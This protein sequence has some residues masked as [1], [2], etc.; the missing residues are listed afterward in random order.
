MRLF[1]N[2]FLAA[3]FS[4]TMLSAHACEQYRGLLTK[5]AIQTHG[6][7]APVAMLAGHIEQES[8]C[9]PNAR[10]RVGALGLAQ[11]MPATAADMA[12]FHPSVCSPANPFDPR[13]AIQCK[14]RYLHSLRR[15]FQDLPTCSSWTFAL[16]SYNGGLGWINRELRL[17]MTTHPCA[18]CCYEPEVLALYNA[19]RSRANF[20]E[21]TEYVPRILA[22]STKYVERGWGDSICDE[23]STSAQ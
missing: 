10:S 21:N 6:P 14:D 17:C 22:R 8:A 5:S 19:G 15:S 18:G 4:L 7:G 2:F 3:T 20:I 12:K 23:A 1:L 11:F 9:N 13:W 16:R